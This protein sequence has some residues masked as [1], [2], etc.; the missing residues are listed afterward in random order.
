VI[1]KKSASSSGQHRMA[2][3]LYTFPLVF[4]TLGLGVG[5]GSNRPN[6]LLS[7]ILSNL[8]IPGLLLF[9][10][11]LYVTRSF[12]VEVISDSASNDNI[13]SNISACGWAFSIEMFA[14]FAAGAELTLPLIW[15]T[16]GILIAACRYGFVA[17]RHSSG[18]AIILRD[19]MVMVPSMA[20][21]V[22]VD[23]VL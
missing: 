14:M 7:Y 10:Y 6:G 22:L 12:V 21:I 3:S 17:A 15:V 23:A 5:L 4:Q 9:L 20:P 11:M 2:T 1:L 19:P 16:W 8:G 18:E 13:R